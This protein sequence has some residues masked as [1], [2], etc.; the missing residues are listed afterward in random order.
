[1]GYA[2]LKMLAGGAPKAEK[3]A[4]DPKT[5]RHSKFIA[6]DGE[7]AAA[8]DEALVFLNARRKDAGLAPM[9]LHTFIPYGLIRRG[10]DSFYQAKAEFEANSRL[11]KTP[12]ELARERRGPILAG[13]TRA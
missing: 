11:V 4:P 9:D 7:L 10:L 13:G 1:M 8:M 6:Y 12:D 3:T 5:V 2:R